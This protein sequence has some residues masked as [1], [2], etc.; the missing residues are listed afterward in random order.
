MKVLKYMFYII[1][2]NIFLVSC[3]KNFETINANIDDPTI[4]PSS[5]IIG[6]VVRDVSNQLYSAF[7]GNEIGENWI[8]HQS[9]IQY[10]DPD[11]YKPRI[12]SMDGMWNNFYLD[13][14]NANQM[15]KLAT[16]EG[17]KINQGIALVM[18][19]YCFT[20]L[21]DF[22]GD[23][24]YTEALKGPS[25]GVF[26]TAYDRQEVVYEGIFATLDE[27]IPLLQSGV[28][29][30]DPN[31]DILYAGDA[32]KWVKFA[33]TLKFRALMRI[34]GVKDVKA[35]LQA[36]VDGGYLFSSNDD[37]AKLVYTSSS[38]EANPIF[39]Q[40]IAGGR[41]EHGVSATFVNYLTET[42]DPRLPVYVQ[43]N[44]ATGDY[45]GKPNGYKDSPLPG[46]GYDDVS[47]IGTKYLE[48]T[49]P[50]YFISYTELLFLFAE[51]AKTNL[52][53]GGDAAAEG[54]YNA[55]IMNSFAENGVAGAAD[56]L[57][58]SGIV[59][60][61]TNALEQIGSQKW[62]SL[63]TQ[64]FEAWTEWRRTGFP[65]LQPV[66][67]GYISEIPSRLK[68]ESNESSVNTVNYKDAIAAQ[69]SDELTTPIWWMK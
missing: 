1:M 53:S 28:G 33:S 43:P 45:V 62:V 7:N 55:A 58:K 52:I 60:S 3:D 56:F 18:K 23:I 10:N 25:D 9:L 30:T 46:F 38:P 40:I 26:T 12:S 24:P 32:S 69:G 39:E 63:F 36:L 27:A 64:G 37:E 4:I 19:A 48:A 41:N 6:T 15:Y 16:D 8:Q 17:N 61:S 54:Y 65:V 44:A 50:G 21:T 29:T 14:S 11:R 51:A 57:G 2:I 35:D 34:S 20:L 42:G 47:Q 13:A 68:Y 59:Y 49:A 5:M 67:D 66:V 22:Y 31:M